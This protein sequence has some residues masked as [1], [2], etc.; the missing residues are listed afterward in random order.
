MSHEFRD[1]FDEETLRQVCESFTTY[2]GLG[3]AILDLNGIVHAAAG[4]QEICTDFHR[5]NPKTADRCRE[6][7]TV[8]ANQLSQ[9][10]KFNIYRCK[11][12][13][14]DAAIPIYLESEHIGNFFTGQFLLEPP[15]V[16]AFERQAETFQFDKRR[17]LNALKRV[18]ILNEA[19]VK[20]ALEYLVE[21]V[22][23][24]GVMGVSR[25]RELRIQEVE[26]ARLQAMVEERTRELA[27]VREKL[28]KIEKQLKAHAS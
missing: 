25:L 27:L 8:L 28:E 5:V 17:Y 10:N 19:E 22:Q 2:S 24:I 15:D 26:V 23:L 16:I 12:G 7:D 9:G 13:L 20:R 4:W 1:V 21:L 18:P 6:S 3:T 11:N 14:V